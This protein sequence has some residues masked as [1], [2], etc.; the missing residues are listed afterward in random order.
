M[1]NPLAIRP[2]LLAIESAG[3]IC[4]AALWIDSRLVAESNLVTSHGHAIELAPMIARIAAEHDFELARLH[5]V[6]VTIGP[7]GFTGIRVGLAMARGL[8]LGTG[9]EA[10][11]IDAFQRLAQSA[12]RN[13]K[14]LSARNLVIIDSRRAELFAALLD[15]D[16]RP[17][18]DPQLTTDPSRVARESSALLVIS[19]HPRARDWDCGS[20]PILAQ[21]PMAAAIGELVFA[22]EGHF[23]LPPEP[24]YLRAPDATQ[25]RHGTQ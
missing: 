20:P 8:A 17:R 9:C 23:R 5:A 1:T 21:L 13:G 24:R 22:G 10:I 16:L 6:A 11:G 19:D 14:S 15:Q 7:G 25:P 2:N 3:A 4:G 12:R 18:S